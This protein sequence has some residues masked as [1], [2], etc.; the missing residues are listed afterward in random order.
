MHEREESEGARPTVGNVLGF[1]LMLRDRQALLRLERRTL[2]PGLRLS[3]YEAEVPDVEFPLR[4]QGAA[5]FRRRRARVRRLHL[6]VETHA[7]EGWLRRR[8]VGH[9]LAGL[10][11]DE[12][13]LALTAPEPDAEVAPCLILRGRHEGRPQWLM[14]AVQVRARGRKLALR[15]WQAWRLGEGRL[16]IETAWRVLVQWLDGRADIEDPSTLEVDPVR[17]ALLRPFIVAGWRTPDLGGLVLEQVRLQA[18]RAE[19]T[20]VARGQGSIAEPVPREAPRVPGQVAA[21]TGRVRAALEAGDRGRACAELERLT[22]TLPHDHPARVP[23]LQ[24][25]V[26][27]SRRTEPERSARALGAWLHETPR[28]EVAARELLIALSRAGDD[29][30]LARRLAAECRLPQPAPRRARLELALALT[31]VDRLDEPEAGIELLAP[32]LDRAA[33][34][35]QLAPLQSSA[36]GCM[37]RAL[38]STPA[39]ALEHLRLALAH[40][41]PRSSSARASL[42]A[43]VASAL[44]R[45]GHGHA[46]RPLW[47]EVV[48]AAPDDDELV[49]AALASARALDHPGASIELL[50]AAV[51]EASHER[52]LPLRSALVSTL[53]ESPDEAQR[54]LGVAEL[55]TLVRDHPR[56]RTLAL[57]LLTLERERGEPQRAAVLLGELASSTDDPDD[58]VRLR[59]EQAR[60]LAEGGQPRRAWAN[61]QPVLEQV[62]LRLEP[63]LLELA[64]GIAPVSARDALVD[65]LVEIDD[66]P[67]SGRALLGR[68]QG[69]SSSSKKQADLALAAA[70]LD[71]PR[72]ALRELV[73][74]VDAE[75]REP[76]QALADACARHGDDRGE[77][78]ARVELAL[79]HLAHDDAGAAAR[80]LGR[81]VALAPDDHAL[82]LALGW[83]QATA[84]DA[85]SAA[86]SL[87]TAL[88][89][90][91]DATAS[92]LTDPRLG[93]PP[94]S[95]RRYA[96]LGHILLHAGHHADAVDPLRA[97][98]Q[99]LGSEAEPEL[100]AALIDALEGCGETT[101]ASSRARDL[102]DA[103]HGAERARWLAR[104]AQ[105]ATPEHAAAWLA[106]A[107]ELMPPDAPLDAQLVQRLERAARESGDRPALRVAL[108][109]T[110]HDSGRPAADRAR[111]LRDLV[112]QRQAESLSPHDDPELVE[113]CRE[114]HE[115]DPHDP[116]ALLVLAAR[117]HHDGHEARAIARWERALPQLAAA[118]PRRV[119]PSLVLAR[120]DVA[121]GRPER[122]RDLLLPVLNQRHAPAST[123]ELLAEAAVALG[124]APN[125]L[126]AVRGIIAHAPP[127]RPRLDAELALAQQ[128]GRLD[129]AREALPHA[130]AAT[131]GSSPGSPEHVDAARAW[132]SLAQ[133]AE[134]PRQESAAR[135][136]LRHGLGPE[137]SAKELRAEA[138]L[139]AEALADPEGARALVEQALSERPADEMLLSTLEHLARLTGSMLPYLVAVEAAVEATVPGPD[140]DRLGTELALTAA[141]LGDAARVHRALDRVS[142]QAAASEELLDL[143]D[144]AVRQLGLEDD[145]LHRI[146]E[147]LRAGATDPV[148]I[149]RLSRLVG[150]GEASVDHLVALA[151]GMPAEQVEAVLQP[152]ARLATELAIP[153]LTMQV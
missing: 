73:E 47:L 14:L 62:G 98:V 138:M 81:A 74:L 84:G 20:A 33:L 91:V 7:L 23:A 141:D 5:A 135:Q 35:P 26:A 148:L 151:D 11:V 99:Q 13:E 144:W 150:H 34:D 126:R 96:A 100:G 123:Y 120:Y 65:R 32:L 22:D 82:R 10:W 127:D 105:H 111:A 86:A 85:G 28:D 42:R 4:A 124:D 38:A 57:K 27:L 136:Q 6:T 110:A 106:E 21:G 145:E 101:E 60:M 12:V 104:A 128:L 50:R 36:H 49:D 113:L 77:R 53:L 18:D 52:T 112:S 147:R 94:E 64:I 41:D 58:R 67:R 88:R 56:S 68:A 89:G 95:A 93:L 153:S 2:V 8:L 119:E 17:A 125:H 102:A 16:D 137:L 97:A 108:Q 107:V 71:D 39:E 43:A 149:A 103:H 69:R 66:G 83:A 117:D 78:H 37:A 121:R 3:D 80:A 63:D 130:A 59:L 114:L 29:R 9:E 132:L 72:P 54:E 48:K 75:Q 115:L 46:A 45:H 31:L 131:Q 133:A 30:A 116:D 134:D 140:R 146:D 24:W 1:S 122:A 76:W 61:L 25:L 139:R 92:P 129:R 15:P 55:R 109:H 79:R 70:R 152:A 90:G 40:T 19:L 44:D 142:G 51:A 143:R 87:A 118:D